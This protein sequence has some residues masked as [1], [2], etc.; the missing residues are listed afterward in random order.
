MKPALNRFFESKVVRA[1]DASNF[2]LITGVL[3]TAIVRLV[4]RSFD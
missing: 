1:L 3:L 4:W 2:A